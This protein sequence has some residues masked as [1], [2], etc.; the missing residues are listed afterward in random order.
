ML[1]RSVIE[2]PKSE[3]FK[4]QL[5]RDSLANT[6][7]EI[8]LVVTSSTAAAGVLASLDWEEVTR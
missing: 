5:E 3:L 7:Y 2:I 8:T 1:F 6:M 4:F